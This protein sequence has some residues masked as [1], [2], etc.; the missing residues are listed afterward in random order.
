MFSSTLASRKSLAIIVFPTFT[1]AMRSL[2]ANPL[3]VDAF[4]VS[5][6]QS[7]VQPLRIRIVVIANLV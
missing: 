7:A 2:S 1:E 5:H 3:T 6:M 4:E